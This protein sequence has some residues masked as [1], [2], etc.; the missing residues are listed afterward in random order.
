MSI[1]SV[2]VYMN[3]L[4]CGRLILLKDK[5]IV[6]EYTEDNIQNINMDDFY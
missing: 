4:E 5:K 2:I 3:K 6:S 1:L